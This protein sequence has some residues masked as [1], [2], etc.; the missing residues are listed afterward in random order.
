[1]T[2]THRCCVKGTLQSVVH[3]DIVRLAKVYYNLVRKHF[4]LLAR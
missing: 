1:M 4:T 2:T 3:T